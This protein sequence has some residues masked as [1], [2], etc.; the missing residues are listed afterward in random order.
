MALLD[1]NGI[2]DEIVDKLKDMPENRF[3]KH[4]YQLY[5]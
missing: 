5:R 2:E 4:H 1:M 3:S